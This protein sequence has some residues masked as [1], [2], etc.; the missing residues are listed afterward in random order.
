MFSHYISKIKTSL[1]C[2]YALVGGLFKNKLTYVLFSVIALLAYAVIS[3]SPSY[4]IPFSYV[5]RMNIVNSESR[6]IIQDQWE[7]KLPLGTEVFSADTITRL[8]DYSG[9]WVGLEAITLPPYSKHT[10]ALTITGTQYYPEL[11]EALLARIDDEAF[12]ESKLTSLDNEDDL[13]SLLDWVHG[14][15]VYSGFSPHPLNLNEL[16]DKGQGDCTEFTLLAYHK[17]L[18]SG[19]DHVVPVE[20]YYLPVN[21]SKIVKAGNGHAWLL[22]KKRGSWVIVDP[23]YKKII[24]PSA[25]Y[26]VMN[27]LVEG[28]LQKTIRL[29]KLP[30]S[31]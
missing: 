14:K 2:M 16:L 5:Q 3:Y 6:P 22:I 20:G 13:E 17:L 25:E 24:S 7:I 30:L 29:S 19:Y 11:P 10:T 23:L 9:D 8:E 15:L 31:F 4:A 28:T 18:A 26:V 21:E 1:K 12:S 27:T